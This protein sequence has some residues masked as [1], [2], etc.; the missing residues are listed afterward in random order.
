MVFAKTTLSEIRNKKH[1]DLFFVFFAF[2]ILRLISAFVFYNGFLLN[3]K[4]IAEVVS[5][6]GIKSILLFVPYHSSSICLGALAHPFFLAALIAICLPLF[7]KKKLRLLHEYPFFK[8]DKIIIVISAFLLSWEL[9]TYDYNYYLN[10][11][12]HFD[13]FLLIIFPILLWR[14]PFLSPIYV[15]FAMVYR[16]QFNYPVDGFDLFDKR[17]LLDILLMFTSFVY[18]RTYFP[19]TNIR[20][21]FLVLCI[22]ASN[23]C[24]SGISKL[25]MSPHGYEWLLNNR[26]SDL[27]LNVNQRGW[28][29]Q[30]S[31]ESIAN[32]HTVLLKWNVVFQFIVLLLEIAAVFMF[33]NI[34]IAIG[35]LLGLCLMH[36][37]IFAVGSMLFWKWMTIDLLMALLLL[38]EKKQFQDLFSKADFYRS[39]I[40]VLTSVIWLRP[41]TI[42][43]HDTRMN[44]FFTYE[45]EDVNGKVAELNKND[46]DPYH[47]WIQYDRFLFLVNEKCLP[48]SGFGY[49]GKYQLKQKLDEM[50]F[51]DLLEFVVSQGQDKYDHS[52]KVAYDSFMRTFFTNRNARSMEPLVWSYFKAPNHLY[53]SVKQGG[54][55]TLGKVEKLRV[56]Y[57]LTFI[58]NNKAQQVK[59]LMI[60]EIII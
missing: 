8:T 23:Y 15:A 43:W 33:R 24:I 26:V 54:L 57:N 56:Y 25:V 58:T 3:F 40:I 45:A 32:I 2:L 5:S 20:F 10:N 48:I 1:A 6:Q 59:K 14:F 52:T 34:K 47:Q 13:R 36:A 41:Y 39:V 37:A 9:C 29:S 30:A 22:I 31:E 53:N 27:F 51:D 44:Q 50:G 35:L 17:L 19:N 42:G 28:L 46:F 55:N 11:A 16:S 60:D 4:K 18:V 49:T 7:Y 38:K 21:V 12:F